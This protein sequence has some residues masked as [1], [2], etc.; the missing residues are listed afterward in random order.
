MNGNVIVGQSG[1]P[2]SVINSSLAGVF[3]TAKDRG[4]NKVYGMIHGIKGLLDRQYVELSDK[5]NTTMA[6][7]LLKRTPSSY[8]GS[9]RYK[10]PEIADSRE[11]YEKIFAILDEL[12]I[13]Y[14]LY[15]GGNDSMDT[16]KKLSDY[17]KETGSAIKFM[18]VPKTIDNDLAITDHTPG[19]G[20]AAKFIAATMKEIIRDGL[21]YDYPTITV[22]EIMGR[23][24]GW[25]TSAAALAKSDDCEGVD[26][27]YLPE[28]PFDV[29][30]FIKKIRNL[31]KTGRSIV[32]AVSEGIKTAD[33]K[34][35]FELAEHV[36]FVDAFGHKQ[37]SGTAK[38]L[39]NK[40]TAV[41]GLKARAIEL[42]TLQ[43]CAAHM[44]SRTDITEAYN[45]GG[46][47]IK[48]AF[49]GETGK[50]VVLKRVSDDPYMCITELADVGK[51][52]NVEKKVPLEWI[53]DDDYVAQDLIHYIHPLIQAE[54]SPIMVDGLPR[55]LKVN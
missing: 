21:V 31:S 13:G 33:G 34:F 27:I 37:M 49:E 25:L 23:N 41:L 7:D 55:H 47:A 35:V 52:A 12:E 30:K 4:A 3:K 16:I 22:V 48:A 43:R 20:S 1:G 18:G 15:I 24:A 11:T 6:I 50:V 32:V 17:A 42:S 38:F 10:L 14:F 53:T 54:L 39:A 46:A 2:T 36:E 51:I 40:I 44:T 28:K 45:V 26:L 8:L 9:C 5:L 19:F 29:E